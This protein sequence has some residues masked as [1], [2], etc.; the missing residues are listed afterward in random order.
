M[1]SESFLIKTGPTWESDCDKLL[2]ATR[3]KA[4]MNS[5]RD[6][7]C[8]P[9]NS[10]V[11]WMRLGFDCTV[12]HF[13]YSEKS[14]LDLTVEV[15]K[16]RSRNQPFLWSVLLSDLAKSKKINQFWNNLLNLLKNLVGKFVDCASGRK[17]FSFYLRY[18][19]FCNYCSL[20]S[21]PFLYHIYYFL[22]ILSRLRL[23]LFLCSF[24]SIFIYT[25]KLSIVLAIASFLSKFI[26]YFETWNTSPF[27]FFSSHLFA[28]S[29]LK[30]YEYNKLSF[31]VPLLLKVLNHK[32]HLKLW[33]T[34]AFFFFF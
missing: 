27:H 28:F 4:L 15:S 5:I 23:W 25:S 29:L 18:I 10:F 30:A 22:Y 17:L 32:V 20:F 14:P 13:S 9:K 33:K 11:V 8:S 21:N 6:E 16:K 26:G 7:K 12:M 31:V 19:L 3:T 2:I 24:K 1:V 34:E